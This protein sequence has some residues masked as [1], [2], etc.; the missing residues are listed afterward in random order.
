MRKK[1]GQPFFPTLYFRDGVLSIPGYTF[2]HAIPWNDTGS[3]TILAEGASLK[4]GSN[5]LAKIAPAQSNG[6]MCLEREAHILGRMAASND[7]H[8][9]VLRMV[10]FF[11]IP[12]ESGD[13]VV[14][15]LTHPGPNLLGR[16]L[17][18]QKINDL[19]LA[20]ITR[21]KPVSNYDAFMSGTD[22]EFADEIEAFDIMDLASFLEFAIQATRCLE[23]LH[24]AG[25]IHREVR[26][27]AF[28]L[29]SHSGIV[30]LVHVGNRAIS[31]ENF[32]SPSSLVLRAYEESEKLKIKEALCYLAP[33]QTGSI[34]TMTQDH[35]TDLYSLG[36]LFWTLLVGRGQM[37]FEGGA[38]ELLHSI[39]Q[40]RPMPVH[41]VRRDIPQVLAS[42]IDKLLV[43]N[44]DFRYQSAY[45][46]GQDL[47]ECQRRLL[48]TV[49]S[50]ADDSSEL[51]P[52]F[53]IAVQD[54][55]IEFTMPIALF[56][57]DKELETIRNVI[58]SVST[59][60]SR[61]FSVTT[62]YL[63][64]G[65]TSSSAS[66][67][68][69]AESISS[70]SDSVYNATIDSSPRLTDSADFMNTQVISSNP[71]LRKNIIR[72]RSRVSRTQT[73]LVV[74]PPGIGKSSMVLAN[75]AKWRS[76]G[77]WGQAK[78][79][80]AESAP[81]AALLGCLSAV[82]RQLMVFHTDLHRFVNALRERLGPQLHNVP[83]L[84]Q[85]TPELKDVLALFDIH[86]EAPH[87]SLNSPELRVRF[88]SL[89]ENVFT[90]IAETRLFALF[91]DDLHEADQSTLDL[92]STLVNS[93]SRMLIFATLRSDKSEIVTRVSEMFSSRAR[94]TW[95]NV[96]PLHYA[97]I[98]SLVSKTLHRDVEE[99]D[100]LSKFVHKASSGNA[101][102]ARSVLTTLQRQHMITFNWEHN[103]WIF[104]MNAIEGS[105]S[106][107]KTSDPTDLTFLISHL[108]ELPEETRKYLVWAAF[109]GETFKVTEVALM[110]DWE[111]S[112]AAVSGD[113]EGDDLHNLHRAVN[114][115]RDT[116]AVNTHKSTRG[117]Q[118]AL[119]EGW[120]ITRARD[121][122]S[123][124]H[125]RYRQAAQAEIESL[126]PG[127]IAKMSYRIV[128]MMIH[129]APV[130]VYRIA[131]HAKRCLN[132][133]RDHPKRD[134]LLDV[135][136][137][138]GESAWARGAHELGL[139]SFISARNLLGGNPWASKPMRTFKV[140]SRLAALLTWKGELIESDQILEECFLH[141]RQPEDK[142]NILRL[143]ARNHWLRGNY[144]G[145]LNDTLSALKVLGI[146]V[147][148]SPTRRQADSMFEIVK[149]EI[150]AVGF[151]EIVMIP[152]ATDPR[153]E[154]AV[155]LL[156]DAGMN[157]YWSPSPYAFADVIGLTVSYVMFSK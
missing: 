90:V 29:N 28:H 106:D 87:E 135:L 92:V 1:F 86:L 157:A 30:R 60:F 118:I 19:L 104:D 74:G 66:F 102:S 96:E 67:E 147:N 54:R 93:R 151:D 41:E 139:Q 105:L 15:L 144:A 59:S 77:L 58:R 72:N 99:C 65:N 46:L 119:S 129:E 109:F 133:L 36:I 138:A 123:F 13:C 56:G 134:E 16:Y 62:G 154:L 18:P 114:N 5:V 131:E 80:N 85:G 124:A 53:D 122:C 143:R 88:Q 8:S 136:I 98:A 9:S 149:N 82:L 21:I 70:L 142:A 75:Q 47:L 140:L 112:A 126:P 40:K 27:N 64:I 61:H 141:S 22:M 115:L 17:P 148:L 31:L 48:A 79:Q 91:L 145:A 50:A 117:L 38:L 6:S 121:M 152:R 35:R 150:L 42:I 33:E 49:S 24:K 68:D 137:D 127:V 78:F 76:H 84:Y 37:P 116:G 63:S 110:L 103:Y 7:R 111:D 120:L 81:F 125:D 73:I 45:G 100:P 113:D 153:T 128:L 20:D 71:S 25:M 101:F 32:G 97:A 83:L 156:N 69:R 43:K 132:L 52:T 55:F 146:E 108:R 107:Q 26:A 3:M 11:K 12:R 57:R 10:D 89:V 44:P 95:I 2:E 23:S 39:V 130:D 155:S 34:E 14:L 51:I 94:C 4:D